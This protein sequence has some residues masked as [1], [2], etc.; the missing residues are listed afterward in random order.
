MILQAL[1]M[2]LIFFSNYAGAATLQKDADLGI[3]SQA[4]SVEFATDK[5][6]V[7]KGWGAVTYSFR[8]FDAHSGQPISEIKAEN[9]PLVLRGGLELPN[10][11][12]MS[13]SLAGTVRGQTEL[14]ATGTWPMKIVSVWNMRTGAAQWHFKF[15]YGESMSMVRLSKDGKTVLACADLGPAANYAQR[16]SLL[17]QHGILKDLELSPEAPTAELKLQST[18]NTGFLASEPNFSIDGTQFVLVR[19]FEDQTRIT[20]HEAIF[21]DASTGEALYRR[22]MQD[23]FVTFSDDLTMMAATI[24]HKTSRTVDV[25]DIATGTLLSR[26]SMRL[27]SNRGFRAGTKSVLFSDRTS[28]LGQYGTREISF[29]FMDALTGH[30]RETVVNLGRTPL[31]FSF[32]QIDSDVFFAYEPASKATYVFDLLDKGEKLQEIAG[33]TSRGTS[34]PT[35]P[36]RNAVV[37]Q[38]A[39]GE[40]SL[41]SWR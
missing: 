37:L 3:Q 22:K 23:T 27:E 1:A 6:L 9:I 19:T 33:Y 28:R 5:L 11:Q 8:T 24:D 2:G 17:N 14:L 13:S 4:Y 29:H 18:L 39:R 31:E 20:G 36:N 40:Y 30:I 21:F 41:W 34:V 16:C 12:F 26:A 38:N 25:Q 35:S 15:P 10:P 32:A 7:A